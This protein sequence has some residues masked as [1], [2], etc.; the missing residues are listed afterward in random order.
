M[1]Q[2][3]LDVLEECRRISESGETE[4]LPTSESRGTERPHLLGGRQYEV[5]TALK[6][7]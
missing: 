6:T 7:L 2:Q 1:N 4:G 5:L 3:R